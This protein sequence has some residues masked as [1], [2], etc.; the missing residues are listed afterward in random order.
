MTGCKR[1]THMEIGGNM[2]KAQD[3]INVIPIQEAKVKKFTFNLMEDTTDE[4]G[5][6][7]LELIGKINTKLIIGVAVDAIIAEVEK[8]VGKQNVK[9]VLRF[10]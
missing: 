3:I 1:W 5:G 6:V 10:S 7:D 4:D 8:Q 9:N 2:S